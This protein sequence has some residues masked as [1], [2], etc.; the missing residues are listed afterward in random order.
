MSNLNIND[1][2]L[3]NDER[4]ARINLLNQ[5][6]ELRI[7]L[8][9]QL[10]EFTDN[11]DKI[12]R[13][14]DGDELNETLKSALINKPEFIEM[15]IKQIDDLLE[16][17]LT[18]EKKEDLRKLRRNLA[19]LKEDLFNEKYKDIK[20]ITEDEFQKLCSKENL[21]D[22]EVM[23][24][25]KRSPLEWWLVVLEEIKSITDAQANYLKDVPSLYIPDSILTDNQKQILK[26]RNNFSPR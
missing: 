1:V 25:V 7:N 20:D 23:Q 9:N 4:E 16:K 11:N 5:L 10:D 8:L 19:F 18:E 13:V 15:Y 2:S 17:E 12:D 26:H 22:D 14:F 21:T 24:I 6:D 3:N